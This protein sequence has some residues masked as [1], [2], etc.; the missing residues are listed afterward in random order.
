MPLLQPPSSSSLLKACFCVYPSALVLLLPNVYVS[1]TDTNVP[2]L[3]PLRLFVSLNLFPS[4]NVP[5]LLWIPKPLSSTLHHSPSCLPSN[6]YDQT[7]PSS[8]P[9]PLPTT[10]PITKCIP[11]SLLTW[12][13]PLPL[14]L[15]MVRGRRSSQSLSALC[16]MTSHMT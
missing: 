9:S 7:T 3:P 5:S 16:L 10:R 4:I 15:L 2:L 11:P 1:S 13:S 14:L 12:R 8:L 6:V